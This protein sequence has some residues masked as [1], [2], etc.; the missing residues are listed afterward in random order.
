M[1][2]TKLEKTKEIKSFTVRC[3]FNKQSEYYECIKSYWEKAKNIKEF[4]NF[5]FSDSTLKMTQGYAEL[6]KEDDKHWYRIREI[7]GNRQF[8]TNIRYNTRK[9]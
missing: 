7:F 6:S 2:L 4:K 5:I 8:K 3:L 1:N 9:I